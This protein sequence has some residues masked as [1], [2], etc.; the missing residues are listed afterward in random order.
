MNTIIFS[1][2]KYLIDMSVGWIVLECFVLKLANFRCTCKKKVQDRISNIFW[3]GFQY[4]FVIS[5]LVFIQSSILNID[6]SKIKILVKFEKQWR[7]SMTFISKH[8]DTIFFLFVNKHQWY[9]NLPYFL[10]CGKIICIVV[11]VLKLI[12]LWFITGSFKNISTL[13]ICVPIYV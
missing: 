13:C 9:T 12:S 8:S 1:A 7:C 5:C 2:C 3:N 11:I 10:K 4:I 6:G